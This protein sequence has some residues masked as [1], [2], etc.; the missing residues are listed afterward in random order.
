MSPEQTYLSRRCGASA[1][2]PNAGM[3]RKHVRQRVCGNADG[4]M[5]GEEESEF[6]IPPIMIAHTIAGFHL[7]MRGRG[8][9]EFVMTT[10][11]P[12]ETT[13]IPDMI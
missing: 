2:H 7:P 5:G 13:K 11:H 8:T 12:S 3:W 9:N 6:H 4:E 1:P 10:T